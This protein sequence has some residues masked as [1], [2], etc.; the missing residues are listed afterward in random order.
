MVTNNHCWNNIS[1]FFGIT[2]LQY[3]QLKGTQKVYKLWSFTIKILHCFKL[4]GQKCNNAPTNEHF[5]STFRYSK[6]VINI[7]N[8][9]CVTRIIKVVATINCKHTNTYLNA[10]YIIFKNVENFKK[11]IPKKKFGRKMKKSFEIFKKYSFW[12]GIFKIN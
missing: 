2:H 7:F 3:S 1:Y 11:Q 5:Y 9:R 12:N 4:H 10:N 6:H 8:K